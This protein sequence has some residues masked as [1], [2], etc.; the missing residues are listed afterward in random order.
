MC[1]GRAS[2]R[3][4]WKWGLAERADDQVS[5][6]STGMK[7]KLSIAR[8]LLHRPRVLFLD[9][10]TSGLDPSFARGIRE[11]VLALKD[12]GTTVFLTTHYMEEAEQLCDRVA[13]IDAGRVVLQDS[14]ANL[15]RS[16]GKPQ[17]RVELKDGQTALLSLEA[18]DDRRQLATW[19]EQDALLTIHSQEA[20]LEDVFVDVVGRGIEL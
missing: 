13:F 17:V 3:C 10:P 16:F 8:A 5:D 7:Q 12:A 20:T 15:K 14:P 9:E 2:T 19:V 1:R 6:F 18:E 11:R 4:C